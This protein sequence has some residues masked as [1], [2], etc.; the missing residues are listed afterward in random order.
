MATG[1]ALSLA[2][3]A[4]SLM[5]K[6][7]QDSNQASLTVAVLEI[8]G[9]RPRK[10]VG[11]GIFSLMLCA[12]AL[13]PGQDED[14]FAAAINEVLRPD[15]ACWQQSVGARCYAISCSDATCESAAM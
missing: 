8:K 11:S 15:I 12:G 14:Q 4:S 2:A 7:S 10:G 1:G 13:H 9:L 3:L 6:H 5:A